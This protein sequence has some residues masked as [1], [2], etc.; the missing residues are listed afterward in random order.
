MGTNCFCSAT[1]PGTGHVPSA[2]R[3]S[4]EVT[5]PLHFFSSSV[6]VPGTG[7]VGRSHGQS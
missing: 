3:L 1:V 4:R 6:T 7:R 2:Y 5:L